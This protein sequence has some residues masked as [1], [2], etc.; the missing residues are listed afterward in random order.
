MTLSLLPVRLLLTVMA[1]TF[2]CRDCTSS[3]DDKDNAVTT[4]PSLPTTT[5]QTTD[6]KTLVLTRSLASIQTLL[7]SG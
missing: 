2:S 7:T 6:G 3:L 4:T 5:L 1:D